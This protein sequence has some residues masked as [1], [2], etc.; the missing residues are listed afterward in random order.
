MTP[1]MWWL[2]SASSASNTAPASVM[3][4]FLRPM[5]S[6]QST[7]SSALAMLPAPASPTSFALR[8]TSSTSK[9][10][11]NASARC[12]APSSPSMLLVKF[13]MLSGQSPRCNARKSVFAP[14]LVILLSFKSKTSKV[15]FSCKLSASADTSRSLKWHADRSS[16]VRVLVILRANKY[17]VSS[18]STCAGWQEK[19]V[20]KAPAASHAGMLRSARSK[21]LA[22]LQI[23]HNRRRSSSDPL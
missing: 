4:L 21:L 15:L 10:H 6:G 12:C 5:T 23:L 7:A 19:D 14:S 8:L 13:S 20:P 11:R 2:S 9:P 18:R 1:K 3:R 16:T 22:S 17:D